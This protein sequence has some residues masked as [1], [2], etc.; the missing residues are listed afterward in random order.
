VFL[1]PLSSLARNLLI[2][3][4]NK[5]IQKSEIFHKDIKTDKKRLIVTEYKTMNFD[6]LVLLLTRN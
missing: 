6:N 3:Q 2:F 5:Q 1:C 4:N